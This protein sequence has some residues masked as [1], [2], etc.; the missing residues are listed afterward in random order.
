MFAT[1]RTLF[2]PNINQLLEEDVCYKIIYICAT[3]YTHSLGCYSS[4]KHLANK[5][6]V[7]MIDFWH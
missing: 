3:P 4:V 7:F 2:C 5:D 6:K 1:Y